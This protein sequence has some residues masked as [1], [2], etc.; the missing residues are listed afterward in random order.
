MI[1]FIKKNVFLKYHL[2]PVQI[3]SVAGGNRIK[4]EKNRHYV[5][6]QVSP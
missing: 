1:P 2:K 4:E 5:L 3:G 6:K